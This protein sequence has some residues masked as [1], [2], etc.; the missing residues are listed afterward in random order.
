MFKNLHISTKVFLILTPLLVIT[1][2]VIVYSTYLFQEQQVLRMA[3]L[4]AESQA[5]IIKKSLVHM[6]QTQEEV[7]D[8]YLRQI[9]ETN[10]IEKLQIIFFLDSLRLKP[11]NLLVNLPLAERA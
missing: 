4:S 1:F 7:S 8:S 5:S 2:G 9:S 11:Q 6:M 10:E 3:Q